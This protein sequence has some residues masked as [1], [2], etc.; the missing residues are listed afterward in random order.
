MSGQLHFS[1]SSTLRAKPVPIG[2]EAG[3][4]PE[5]INEILNVSYQ[6]SLLLSYIVSS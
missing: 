2:N 6:S 4:A 1:A 5:P 3:W